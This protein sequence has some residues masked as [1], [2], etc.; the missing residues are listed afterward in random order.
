LQGLIQALIND[1]GGVLGSVLLELEKRH[2][3]LIKH[4]AAKENQALA[5]DVCFLVEI[6][7]EVSS[8]F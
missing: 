4:W 7:N 6:S 8:S 3:E 2:S 1:V 5:K